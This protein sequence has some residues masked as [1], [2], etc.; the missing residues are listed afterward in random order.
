MNLYRCIQ[1]FCLVLLS[2]PIGTSTGINDVTSRTFSVSE[3]EPS[4]VVHPEVLSLSNE[5]V[6]RWANENETLVLENAQLN[7]PLAGKIG[8]RVANAFVGT[9]FK[10][11]SN[12]YPLELS[13]EDIWVVI[14]QGVSI[15]LNENAEKYRQF[16]VSHEDKKTLTLYVD[17]LRISNV[18]RV[19][20]EN[21]SIPAIDWPKAV[22]LM[23]NLI[24]EDMRRDLA[25]VISKPFSQTTAVQQTV[26]DACLMDTV[27][28]Y[29]AYEFGLL[30]GIPQVTLIGSPDDF[31]SVL[32]RLNQLKV[33]FPDLHWWLDPLF[34]HVQNF[35]ESAE[36]NSDIDWWRK[37]CHEHFEGSGD[38]ALTGWLI[39][40]IPYIADGHG[41][42]R[43][44]RQS[45]SLTN[46][47]EVTYGI[48]F[49]DFNEAV[50]Q[51]DFILNDNGVK[52]NMKI[53]A[54][55]LGIGQN[56]TTKA[57]RPVLGWLTAIP[58]AKAPNRFWDEM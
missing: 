4:E 30:C 15:H 10:A 42:Y 37:I 2:C 21:L 58:S 19:S 51:T 12:H 34:S 31:Q 28:K 32:D 26:L 13:V 49:S 46:T 17:D 14:A 11:Y 47:E 7:Y 27:K 43:K 33:F 45:Y 1:C 5:D 6:Q 52:N 36:G 41:H 9:V 16:F 38:T 24:K 22:H 57:L 44:A 50:T 8:H 48:D 40:F 29:Y 39:D 35:K 23:G 54:G 53:I 18:D 3:V 20:G 55:F 25:S 56:P